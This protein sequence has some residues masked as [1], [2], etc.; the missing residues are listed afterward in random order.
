MELLS[1]V[2]EQLIKINNQ[3]NNDM[4]PS[5]KHAYVTYIY[6]IMSIKTLPL[7]KKYE[8]SYYVKQLF[9]KD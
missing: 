6:D 2:M 5:L 7:I 1:N 4:N 9:F 3:K 8:N